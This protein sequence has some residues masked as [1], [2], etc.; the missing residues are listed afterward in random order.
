MPSTVITI[1]ISGG[2]AVA[3][4][5]KLLLRHGWRRLTAPKGRHR[6]G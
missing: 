1:G 4:L 5:T 6:H 3:G 2:L